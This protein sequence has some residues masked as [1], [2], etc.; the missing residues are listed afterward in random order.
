MKLGGGFVMGFSWGDNSKESAL[1]WSMLRAGV[2][3]AAMSA[4]LRL[5]GHVECSKSVRGACKHVDKA[6]ID[7]HI[8]SKCFGDHHVLHGMI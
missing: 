2:P 1:T 5:H 6:R 4:R 7:P 3:Q 8:D